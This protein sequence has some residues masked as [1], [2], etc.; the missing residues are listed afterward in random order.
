MD[1]IIIIFIVAVINY[2]WMN[3]YKY[4]NEASSLKW[5]P[6]N[7]AMVIVILTLQYITNFCSVSHIPQQLIKR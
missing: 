5:L 2:E 7:V 6:S 1:C 4:K 3:E